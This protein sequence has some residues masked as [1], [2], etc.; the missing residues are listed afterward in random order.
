MYHMLKS[1]P[2]SAKDRPLVS[3]SRARP[4]QRLTPLLC[5]CCLACSFVLNTNPQA[6]GLGAGRAR[7]SH[8]LWY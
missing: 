2:S 8:I 4:G 7:R 5:E 1:K 3:P 6:A